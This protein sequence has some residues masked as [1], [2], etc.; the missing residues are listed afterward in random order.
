M[1]HQLHH[2]GDFIEAGSKVKRTD[3]DGRSILALLLNVVS[4]VENHDTFP[5]VDLVNTTSLGIDNESI[6]CCSFD[7]FVSR[8]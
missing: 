5:D 7:S 3:R 6:P 2:F 1:D 8:L 4:L